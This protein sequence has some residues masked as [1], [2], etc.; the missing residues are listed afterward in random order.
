MQGTPQ[1]RWP[2][3]QG[4]GS[5]LADC[6]PLPP[7]R[8]QVIVDAIGPLGPDLISLVTTREEISDLLALDDVIDLV[9][10]RGGNALV[11]PGPP[12]NHHPRNG[13]SC[14][15]SSSGLRAQQGHC[16]RCTP[17]FMRVP[18]RAVAALRG[19]SMDPGAPPPLS[20]PLPR[21]LTSSKTPRS[22]SWVTRMASAISTSTQQLT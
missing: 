10:P 6:K 18:G 22:P 15:A 5:G 8:T 13:A 11:S 3:S 19:A 14:T 1:P 9:I 21:C 20:L 2:L 16:H 7:H 12:P 4:L 17:T